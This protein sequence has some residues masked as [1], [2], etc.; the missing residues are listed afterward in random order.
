[1]S[2][3]AVEWVDCN[4]PP[5]RFTGVFRV[6]FFKELQVGIPKRTSRDNLEFRDKRK[7]E[8]KKGILI[9]NER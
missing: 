2:M 6:D 4:Q 1:M 9:L 8:L 3:V 7:N 5:D